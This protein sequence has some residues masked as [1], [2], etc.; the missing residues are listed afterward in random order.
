MHGMCS[1]CAQPA[2]PMASGCGCKPMGMGM[3]MGM[4]FS[5][6]LHP[7]VLVAAPEKEAAAPKKDTKHIKAAAKQFL[8]KLKDLDF[9]KVVS[10]DLRVE[11]VGD[12]MLAEPVGEEPKEPKEP[13]EKEEPKEDENATHAFV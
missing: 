5:M 9:D 4:P 2:P 10:F 6:P 11:M 7:E 13:K 1:K 3:G 8:D 12:D